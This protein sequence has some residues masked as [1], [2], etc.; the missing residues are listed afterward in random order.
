[1]IVAALVWS[2]MVPSD[3]RCLGT[4]TVANFWWQLEALAL[5]VAATMFCG[6]LQGL[7]GWAPT[8]IDLDPPVVGHH[9]VHDHD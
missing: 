9:A 1:M 3:C 8:E 5:L 4:I 2:Q 7:F 6:W